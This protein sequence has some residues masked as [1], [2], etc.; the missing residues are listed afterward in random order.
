MTF[1]IIISCILILLVYIFVTGIVPTIYLRICNP[2]N[3]IRKNKKQIFLTFDDG[4]HAKYTPLLLDVL[5][6]HNVKATFFIV[7]EFA[8]KNPQ[9]LERI[10]NEGHLIGFHSSS[11]QNQILQ[12]P[13]S[14]KKDFLEGIK[15]F[16]EMGIQINFYRPTWGHMN[17]SGMY[18]CKKLNLKTVLWNVII[19][20][21]QKDTSPQ[22]LCEKLKQKVSN[23]AVICLHDGRGK[24]E[25]PLKTIEAIKTMIPIW[26]TEGYTF[27]KVD[28]LS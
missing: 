5:K 8:K 4:I 18:L 10:K 1:K 11:H 7:A 27:E 20:D 17:L 3:K 21:W 6:E 23:K 12:L 15:I 19:Q 22:I 14:V 26:K 13:H 25:A 9:I 2:L 24:N 16:K 28:E